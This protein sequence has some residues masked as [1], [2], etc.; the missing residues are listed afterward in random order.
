MQK[1]IF[2]RLFIQKTPDSFVMVQGSSMAAYVCW[3]LF[4]RINIKADL[5]LYLA[6]SLF[7]L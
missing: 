2:L 6:S 3:V 7:Q 4:W 1:V 5:M